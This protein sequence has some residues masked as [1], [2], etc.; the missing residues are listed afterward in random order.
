MRGGV[1][2][3]ILRDDFEGMFGVETIEQFLRSSYDQF[4]TA[5][6]VP[7]WPLIA[8]PTGVRVSRSHTHTSP[9]PSPPRRGM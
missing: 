6:T 3:F 2:N 7:V 9:S 5:H 4:A 1:T 8:S